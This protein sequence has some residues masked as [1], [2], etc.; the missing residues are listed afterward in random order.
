MMRRIAG[1][2]IVGAVFLALTLAGASPATPGD[3]G[4][5]DAARMRDE[6]ERR[7]LEVAT[8]ADGELGADL[9][10]RL[11]EG[12][13][14][15]GQAIR[16]EAV[17]LALT[18]VGESREPWP[19]E[20]VE[21]EGNGN[22]EGY[23]E[24][25]L[26]LFGVD[27][28]SLRCR[29]IRELLATDRIRARAEIEHFSPDLDIAIEACSD[30]V[31]A[32][33]RVFYE[34]LGEV[35]KRGFNTRERREGVPWMLARRYV[36]GIESITQVAPAA[37]MIVSIDAPDEVRDVLAGDLSTA[38]SRL[39]PSA[40]GAFAVAFRGKSLAALE[41]LADAT[42][43]KREIHDAFVGALRTYVTAALAAPRCRGLDERMVP[44][45]VKT[46][47]EGLF[48]AKPIL[49]DEM[50]TPVVGDAPRYESFWV[51][52]ESRRLLEGF[53]ELN[54]ASRLMEAD[55]DRTNWKVEYGRYLGRLRDWSARTEPSDYDYFAEK[56]SLIAGM[57]RLAYDE[58]VRGD[59][60]S[61]FVATAR[62]VEATSIPPASLLW[63]VATTLGHTEGSTRADTLEMLRASGARSVAAYAALQLEG[64]DALRIG[65]GPALAR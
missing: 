44:D 59:V 22:R 41:G 45:L 2:R 27:A 46:F 24:G 65:V 36:G 11:L 35:I 42:R 28:M 12:G 52:A 37:G 51:S 63:I 39:T 58:A 29:A 6:R 9:A 33:P 7:L 26:L 49:R 30:G 56:T 13:H 60:L 21:G 48:S 4:E 10:L 8:L 23:R 15:S 53:Q 47:N 25:A 34:T 40:R 5:S 19:L 50:K 61:E 38:I 64:V 31:L 16:R 55:A 1:A 18:R 20:F 57:L 32:S 43:G 3:A 14:L 62:H 54:T 17:D